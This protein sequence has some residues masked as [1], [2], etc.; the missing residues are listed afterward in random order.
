MS[1]KEQLAA[2]GKH[3][4][5]SRARQRR[6][7]ADDLRRLLAAAT[8]VVREATERAERLGIQPHEAVTE[9]MFRHLIDAVD[10]GD[11]GQAQ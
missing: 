8:F 9:R 4:T 6:T 5:Q 7:A 11:N 2:L 1:D 10:G 3:L